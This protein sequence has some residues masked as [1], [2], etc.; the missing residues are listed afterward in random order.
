MLQQKLLRRLASE[1]NERFKKEQLKHRSWICL[2]EV[3]DL[4][5]KLNP[6]GFQDAISDQ[7]KVRATL[8]ELR[9]AII[10]GAFDEAVD[11]THA[12]IVI[13]SDSGGPSLFLKKDV[14]DLSA[15]EMYDP[16]KSKNLSALEVLLSTIWVRSDLLKNFFNAKNWQLPPWLINPVLVRSRVLS[17]A[18]PAAQIKSMAKTSAK[19]SK[20]GLERDYHQR[21][22]ELG[23]YLPTRA[24]DEKWAAENKYPLRSIRELRTKYQART[25]GQ[26][27]SIRQT[28]A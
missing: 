23:G 5:G 27:K 10:G 1:Q 15:A 9:A 16:E 8:I 6:A 11:G 22:N 21:R 26:R 14:R 3:I 20:A 18:P 13:L 28:G 25:A 4:R 17:L 19:H 2:G 7:A 24:E 12:K